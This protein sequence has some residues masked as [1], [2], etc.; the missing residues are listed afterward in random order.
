MGTTEGSRLD[1]VTTLVEAYEAARFQ[2]EAPDPIAAVRF[3]MERKQLSHR[4][5]NRRSAAGHEWRSYSI[6][7]GRW[8]SRLLFRPT[9]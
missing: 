7:D 4:D 1:I 9:S 3:M 5:L 2:I 6:G 8:P